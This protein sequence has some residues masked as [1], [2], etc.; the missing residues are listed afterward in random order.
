VSFI[1]VCPFSPALF[2]RLSGRRVIFRIDD[3]CSSPDEMRRSVSDHQIDLACVWWR[4]QER[5][6]D[7]SIDD[8][9]A[10]MPLALQVQGLGA[11]RHVVHLL[12]LLSRLNVRVYL[13]ARTRSE[14][15][16]VRILSSLGFHCC[17]IIDPADS[18]GIDWQA[19]RDLAVYGL[20]SPEP[21]GDIDPFS[22][23]AGACGE[24][25]DPIRGVHFDDPTRFLHVDAQGRLSL[26][27]ESQ[28]VGSFLEVPLEHCEEVRNL[29]AY[30]DTLHSWKA[31]FVERTACAQCEAW[32]VCRGAVSQSRHGDGCK[33]LFREVL[34]GVEHFQ[35]LRDR[36]KQTWR[37]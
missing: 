6:C 8:G 13:P 10:E 32:R 37:L 29:D 19:L 17:A 2:P 15:A 22:S 16:A 18:S 21:H 4:T 5:L 36:V 35:N 24:G 31:L 9:W 3:S 25:N 23:I 7:L 34:Q 27:R 30:W 26:S 12:D 14:C 33:E 28:R 1:L 20:Y 11:F